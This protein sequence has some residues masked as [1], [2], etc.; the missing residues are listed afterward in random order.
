MATILNEPS[1]KNNY[2]DPDSVTDVF[3]PRRKS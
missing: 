1:V 2:L 3:T